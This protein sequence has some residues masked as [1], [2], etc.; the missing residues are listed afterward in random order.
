MNALAEP[1]VRT[2][3]TLA[4]LSDRAETGVGRQAR[5]PRGYRARF[6]ENREDIQA[7]L[8][9]RYRVF[10]LEL[11]EGPEAAFELGYETDEF[12]AICDHLLVEHVVTGEVVG[13]Y[14]LQTGKIA[15]RNSGYYSEREFDFSVY[16]GLRDRMLELGR[17]CIHPDHRSFTVLSL[18]WGGIA[19]YA[20]ERNVRFLVGCSSLTSQSAVEGWQVYRQL[21]PYLAES[22]LRTC[23]LPS[24]R[25]PEVGERFPAASLR[26]PKLLRAYLSI[27]ARICGKPAI[28]RDFK[29]IDFLTLLDL[30]DLSSVVKARFLG[31]PKAGFAG[32]V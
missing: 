30:E 17:A 31:S 25:L 21:Q 5:C 12:D 22:L 27:G 4:E 6:A 14:R 15:G 16:R 2:A 19:A 20:R 18:L 32:W 8:R 9:L 7:A 29:T 26:P 23:P 10:C 13:T 3:L 11:N 1:V 28:D 24:F